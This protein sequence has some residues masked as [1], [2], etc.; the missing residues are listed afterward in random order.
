MLKP[1]RLAHQLMRLTAQTRRVQQ[2]AVIS[3]TATSLARM[4]HARSVST[5]VVRAVR[6]HRSSGVPGHGKW[7]AA[8]QDIALATPT[9][10]TPAHNRPYS[11]HTPA[12]HTSQ[13]NDA[14]SECKTA[15]R[16]AATPTSPSTPTPLMLHDDALWARAKAE[17][18]TADL[19]T[20]DTSI[21][22]PGTDAAVH[23][24]T[25]PLTSPSM[26]THALHDDAIM[27]HRDAKADKAAADQSILQ[28]IAQL[29]EGSHGPSA[30]TT[31]DACARVRKQEAIIQK[32]K[33]EATVAKAAVD[34]HSS[35]PTTPS[36][37]ASQLYKEALLA[38]TAA[39]RMR[40]EMVTAR[41]RASNQRIMGSVW[42]AY[43]AK[44]SRLEDLL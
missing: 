37:P 33:H 24:A 30:S 22:T 13:H 14:L 7:G 26:P 3:A 16:G 27:A 15:T 23:S 42:A 4:V 28:Q 12:A 6:A 36:T 21:V 5:T 44:L 34:A 31:T 41:L 8:A 1:R 43:T 2:V 17:H 9:C 25:S 19:C 10:H 11:P 29:Y 18:A 38:C 32:L 39:D 20:A 40:A 35:P